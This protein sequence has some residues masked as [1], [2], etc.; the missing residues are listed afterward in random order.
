VPINLIPAAASQDPPTS[1]EELT[2]KGQMVPLLSAE[3]RIIYS[4]LA[5]TLEKGRGMP[6]PANSGQQ[7]SHKDQRIWVYVNWNE[8]LPFK[9]TAT[10]AVYDADNRTLGQ[11]SPQK[12]N[13]HSGVL[14]L[15]TW[16]IPLTTLPSGIYRVDVSL[17]GN[18]VWRKFF[19]L[20]D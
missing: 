14:S 19:R 8:N 12:V 6:T 11:S 1:L 20:A 7:F 16:E 10:M 2:R 17:G 13:L 9:G 4:G 5:L 3:E 18:I 15:T